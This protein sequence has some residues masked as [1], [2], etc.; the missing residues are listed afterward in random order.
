MSRRHP[1]IVADRAGARILR[2]VLMKPEARDYIS[3]LH[4]RVE[5]LAGQA[6][7]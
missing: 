6:T 4:A 2:S 7:G 5:E 1:G 3:E